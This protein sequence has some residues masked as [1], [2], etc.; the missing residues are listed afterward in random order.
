MANRQSST[1]Y[2]RMVQD[3]RKAGLNPMLAYSQGHGEGTVMPSTSNPVSGLNFS[4]KMLERQ[5]GKEQIATQRSIQKLNAA[6]EVKTRAEAGQTVQDV[7]IERFTFDRQSRFIEVK[8]FIEYERLQSELESAKSSAQRAAIGKRI[9][10][11]EEQLT[12][13]AIPGAMFEA[14]KAGFMK[15]FGEGSEWRKRLMFFGPGLL[16]GASSAANIYNVLRK[17]SGITINK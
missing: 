12:R 7:A 8:A 6:Q 16:Q 2:Q 1:S 9:D 17:K 11:L 13:Y 3:L 4:G 15:E 14:Q 5:L 10:E